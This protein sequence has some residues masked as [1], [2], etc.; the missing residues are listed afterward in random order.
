MKAPD[1]LLYR[2]SHVIINFL[3]NIESIKLKD[4]LRIVP[5]IMGFPGGSVVEYACNAG[6]VGSIPGSERSPGEG[7]G[8]QFQH[9][10]LENPM[11][12]GAWWATVHVNKSWTLT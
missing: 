12:R 9:S 8:H 3:I 11:D 5:I 2:Y 1:T 10:C 6:D 7:N 4:Y